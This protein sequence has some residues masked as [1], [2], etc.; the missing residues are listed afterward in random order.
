MTYFWINLSR[1]EPLVYQGVA[2]LSPLP[3]HVHE[4]RMNMLVNRIERQQEPETRHTKHV[5]RLVAFGSR[6]VAKFVQRLVVFGSHDAAELVPLFP[7]LKSLAISTADSRRDRAILRPLFVPNGLSYL[8]LRRL[9][10]LWFMIPPKHRSCRHPIFRPLTHL[11][12]DPGDKSCWDGFSEL[13]N[14]TNM[15]VTYLDV[16]FEVPNLFSSVLEMIRFICQRFPPSLNYMTACF[17]PYQS[18]YINTE[19]ALQFCCQVD[20]GKFDRRVQFDWS[21]YRPIDQRCANMPYRYFRDFVDSWIY[22]PRCYHDFW[23]REELE[24]DNRNR[25]CGLVWMHSYKLGLD[26]TIEK[27]WINYVVWLNFIIQNLPLYFSEKLHRVYFPLC[28]LNSWKISAQYDGGRCS[29][30]ITI[31]HRIEDDHPPYKARRNRSSYLQVR[32]KSQHI[33]LIPEELNGLRKLLREIVIA[34]AL[35]NAHAAGPDWNLADRTSLPDSKYTSARHNEFIKYWL[36]IS[37]Y[38]WSPW[39]YHERMRRTRRLTYTTQMDQCPTRRQANQP[40]R[41]PAP[42]KFAT[43]PH[44]WILSANER[45]GPVLVNFIFCVQGH[46]RHGTLLFSVQEFY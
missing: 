37:K 28:S 10:I 11:Q 7:N 12:I 23:R 24:I 30:L 20:T 44:A 38:Q 34:S 26:F 39:T 46:N 6:D 9:V 3:S 13:H 40:N 8:N 45:R 16:E 42:V 25:T 32:R 35:T 5:Q 2:F 36:R 33:F 1:I 41:T 22:L 21:N 15:R 43:D 29:L 31:L 17:H 4:I 18:G 14:L 27:N 19:E